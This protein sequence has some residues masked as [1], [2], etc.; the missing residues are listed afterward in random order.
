MLDIAVGNLVLCAFK[1]E[2]KKYVLAKIA[3][4]FACGVAD[5]SGKGFRKFGRPWALGVVAERGHGGGPHR[6]EA[7]LRQRVNRPPRTAGGRRLTTHGPLPLV[8]G[9]STRSQTFYPEKAPQKK[10]PASGWTQRGGG[11]RPDKPLPHPPPNPL[12][13]GGHRPQKVACN[14]GTLCKQAGGLLPP[15]VTLLGMEGGGARGSW[16]SR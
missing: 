6:R 13:G 15:N 11:V 2:K 10:N 14:N 12:R 4:Y 7:P 16:L 9:M 5:K 1:I 3:K 8:G